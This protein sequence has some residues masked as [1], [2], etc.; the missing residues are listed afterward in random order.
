V[1]YL[2]LKP[3]VI[4]SVNLAL[5]FFFLSPEAKLFWGAECGSD[6]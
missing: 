2:K 4:K 1:W 5:F 6:E 3:L